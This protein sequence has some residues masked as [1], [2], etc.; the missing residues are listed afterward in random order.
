MKRSEFEKIMKESSFDDLYR[1][2]ARKTSGDG[3]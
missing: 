2:F 1:I 3:E